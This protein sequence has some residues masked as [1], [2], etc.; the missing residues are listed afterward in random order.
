MSE[1]VRREK[2]RG[3]TEETLK[4]VKDRGEAKVKGDKS[5][6]RALNIVFQ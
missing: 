1:R 5:R 3:M 4:M 2:L 6:V